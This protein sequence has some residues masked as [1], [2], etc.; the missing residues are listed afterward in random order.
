M[1]KARPLGWASP[2]RI[3]LL[4]LPAVVADK[5]LG[6]SGN[7]AANGAGRWSRNTD[8][9]DR[10]AAELR[11]AGDMTRES[12]VTV[13]VE[14]DS[15]G[16]DNGFC[17]VT[18]I[19]NQRAGHCI[20]RPRSAAENGPVDGKPFDFEGSCTG[21]QVHARSAASNLPRERTAVNIA[22]WV[23]NVQGG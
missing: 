10:V 19:A 23:V 18:G 13:C 1:E 22:H 15:R 14:R 12:R 20:D 8:E 3:P 2:L 9:K 11:D 5:A 16:I 6:S 21:R 4:D 7:P 17:P